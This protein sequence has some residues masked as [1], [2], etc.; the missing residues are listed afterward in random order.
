MFMPKDTVGDA[1]FGVGDEGFDPGK[2]PPEGAS[3]DLRAKTKEASIDP[4]AG[5]AKL[6]RRRGGRR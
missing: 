2:A 1:I 3:E 5:G 6:D 4:S